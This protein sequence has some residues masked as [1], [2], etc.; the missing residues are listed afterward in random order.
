MVYFL[1]YFDGRPN[2]FNQIRRLS[3]K[4]I[5]TYMPNLGMIRILSSENGFL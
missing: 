2:D 1:L 3:R 5:Y 4:L